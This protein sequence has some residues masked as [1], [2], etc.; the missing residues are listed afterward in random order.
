M[1]LRMVENVNGNWFRIID[2]KKLW[3]VVFIIA[4]C[5]P[6]DG[7]VYEMVVTADGKVETFDQS[8]TYDDCQNKAAYIYQQ[9][10][11]APACR[12]MK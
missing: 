11:V 5:G 3:I 6:A 1:A 4:G 10:G 8:L 9:S 2:M 7:P 12:K